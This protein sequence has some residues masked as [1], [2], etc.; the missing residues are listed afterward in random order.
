MLDYAIQ[1]ATATPIRL[2]LIS[3]RSSHFVTQSYQDLIRVSTLP[4][5]DFYYKG[6][7]LER[8]AAQQRLNAS[9]QTALSA[10]HQVAL[11]AHAGPRNIEQE[12]LFRRVKGW[13]NKPLKSQ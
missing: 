3:P 8:Q 11:N 9:R 13:L 5:A 10:Y 12:L 1:Y 6:A 2:V 7:S 4:I